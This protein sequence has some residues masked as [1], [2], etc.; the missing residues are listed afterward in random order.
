MLLFN[1]IISIYGIYNLNKL[2]K[3]YQQLQFEKK[4]S[5]E[6][7]NFLEE[8]FD[9]YKLLSNKE[10]KKFL[11]RVFRFKTRLELNI[12]DAIEENKSHIELFVYAACTQ[13]TFGYTKYELNSFKA[14]IVKPEHFYSKLI[15]SEVKGLTL[16]QGYIFYSWHDFQLGYKYGSNKINLALHE[17]AHA[18]YIDKFHNTYDKSWDSWVDCATI[19]LE[20][21]KENPELDFFRN[22]GKSNLSQ[23]W[24]VCIEC[25]FEDPIGF[26]NNHKKLYYATANVLNQDMHLRYT[27]VNKL[28]NH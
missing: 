23:F 20:V 22:Y 14:I 15:Q 13:I 21:L 17:L 11:S 26:L 19:E 27:N 24:A 16:G 12:S 5:Y 25:F 18:L 1:I 8:K 6:F 28:N 2:W 3:Y 4:Q 7:H 10:K 9:Y